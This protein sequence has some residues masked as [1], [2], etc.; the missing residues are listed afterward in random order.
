[1]ATGMMIMGSSG[2]GKTTLGKMIAEKLGYTYIDVDEYI[3]R[4]DTE[5]RVERV[6][7]R[8]L[9][10][11]GERILEGGDMYEQHQTTLK[12]V[13]GYDYGIGGCTLQ[14]HEMWLKSLKCK[15]LRLD[16]KDELEKNMQ[17]I[18][19]TYKMEG[20]EKDI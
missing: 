19:E 13:A 16:G 10:L 20:K 7:E 2:A 3:W 17:I 12:N 5:I 6:H 15:V 4:Q 14:Q 18:V 8:A 1:M 9:R 11:F